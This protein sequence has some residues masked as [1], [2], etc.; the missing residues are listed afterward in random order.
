MILFSAPYVDDEG[1]DD[2]PS[3][4]FSFKNR[5][6]GEYQGYMEDA[7]G[8]QWVFAGEKG[9]RANQVYVGPEFSHHFS[10]AKLKLCDANTAIN[11]LTS[12]DQKIVRESMK[13]VIESCVTDPFARVDTMCYDADEDKASVLV[14]TADDQIADQDIPC[15][16]AVWLWG[17]AYASELTITMPTV[18]MSQVTDL[19]NR[20]LRNAKPA[21]PAA[22]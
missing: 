18:S 22:S 8:G 19:V 3:E 16:I 1:A 13:D 10:L 4:T 17:C 6:D 20:V 14:L 11:K 7:L 5:Y 15:E 21:K 2:A 9:G 12:A